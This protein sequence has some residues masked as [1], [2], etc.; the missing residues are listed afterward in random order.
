VAFSVVPAEVDEHEAS[1][2]DPRKLVAHN[3]ALKADWV[4]GKHPESFVLG[5]DTT[6]FI[7]GIVLNKPADLDDARR[8]LGLLSGQT[9]VVFTG[10]SL[11]C[12][13]RGISEDFDVETLVTFKTL[14]GETIDA[15]L[16][17]TQPLDKAGAYGIQDQGERIVDHWDGS[18]T[19]IVGL[20]IEMTTEILTRY[21][22]LPPSA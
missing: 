21:G 11:R 1:D 16:A 15:Y 7:D 10:I 22:L 12:V 9:H 19:N 4:A 17:T 13:S 18:F 20:P 5:A 2:A 3:S 6:V 8:M 14:S